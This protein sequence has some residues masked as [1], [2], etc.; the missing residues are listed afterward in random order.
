MA[1]RPGVSNQAQFSSAELTRQKNR[2]QN[3]TGSQAFESLISFWGNI[4]GM[5]FTDMRPV[6]K[7]DIVSD[8]STSNTLDMTLRG[9]TSGRTLFRLYTLIRTLGRGR[10]GIVEAQA[11]LRADGIA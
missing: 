8:N 2:Y 11:A 1:S 6:V 4:R 3:L 7:F 5:C 10:M 9:F